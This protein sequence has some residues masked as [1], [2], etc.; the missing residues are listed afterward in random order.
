M[1]EKDIITPKRRIRANKKNIY[2]K[3]EKLYS[4]VLAQVKKTTA[5]EP[6]KE[7]VLITTNRSY[8]LQTAEN[9][10]P[11]SKMFIRHFNF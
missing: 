3:S 1:W 10:L 6:A 5:K 2:N 11:P 9:A 7:I 8:I 4:Y